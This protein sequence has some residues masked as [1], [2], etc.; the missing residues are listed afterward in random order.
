M[1]GKTET[2]DQLFYSFSVENCIAKDHSL[3]AM[4]KYVDDILTNLLG[5]FQKLYSPAGRPVLHRN[6][7]FRKCING[8]AESYIKMYS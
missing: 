8:F 7:F 3:R 1:R 6:M 5:E 2:E 4:K